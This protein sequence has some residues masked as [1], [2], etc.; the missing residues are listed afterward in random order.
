ML[1]PLGNEVWPP[2]EEASIGL[3]QRSRTD[4]VRVRT[5]TRTV[6]EIQWAGFSEPCARRSVTPRERNPEDRRVRNVRHLTSL[7]HLTQP[8]TGGGGVKSLSRELTPASNAE[9][10]RH[11]ILGARDARR[12]LS[13]C[14][15]TPRRMRPA[16]QHPAA[17]SAA[18]HSSSLHLRAPARA[19]SWARPRTTCGASAR[20]L[21][22]RRWTWRH[23]QAS[24]R[25]GCP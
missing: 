18:R 16:P 10:V 5:S 9:R 2:R 22:S 3:V 6:G 1:L 14:S 7:L 8:T 25:S 13:C 20:S 24:T 15:R 23:S 19:C 21:R 4:A 11:G 17:R 12:R